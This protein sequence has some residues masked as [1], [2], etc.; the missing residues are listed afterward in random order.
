MSDV[1][2]GEGR[3]VL[4]VSHNMGSIQKLCKSS[5]L[6]QNGKLMEHGNTMKI[7]NRYSSTQLLSKTS[8]KWIETNA[9]GTDIV[10]ILE[11]NVHNGDR[12]A[13]IDGDFSITKSIAITIKYKVLKPGN[14]FTHGANFYNS[15]GLNI[16]N[17][18]D[19]SV[20]LRTMKRE[21][22]IYET[23]MWI[24]K[25]LLSEG[26]VKVS[27][28]LFKPTPFR[29]FAFVEDQIVFN[30]FDK[31]NGDSA[32]GNYTNDFP[33]IVRPLLKWDVKQINL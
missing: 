3:T 14:I 25:N 18:H 15:E 6:L 7:I 27:I 22:G 2:K 5:L 16:F 24:P 26:I 12:K 1:S 9:P 17:S 8:C 10:K 32:R 30:V 11:I 31:L 13:T 23:T 33:G 28:A 4:F 21:I 29:L 19:V 20:E